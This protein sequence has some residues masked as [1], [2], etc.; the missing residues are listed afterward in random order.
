MSATA[1]H[2][3][4]SIV[5][6]AILAAALAALA[7]A[8]ASGAANCGDAVL[9]EWSNGGIHRS[10]PLRCYGE[11]LRR[12]PQDV[13]NY[14]T[15]ADDIE[16]ALL[17]RQRAQGKKV[18]AESLGSAAPASATRSSSATPLLVVGAVGLAL[19]LLAAGSA[20]A[21]LRRLRRRS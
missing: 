13:R 5:L 14:S 16:R 11:A 12:M 8:G 1:T 3:L 7:P 21:A 2:A 4:R 9:A 6:V 15:A 18:G 20:G 19:L 17:A 10:F